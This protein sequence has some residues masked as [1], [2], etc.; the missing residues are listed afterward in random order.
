[1]NRKDP[2]QHRVFTGMRIAPDL[3]ERL[4]KFCEAHK[5]RPTRTLVM[6]TAIREFLD[7][8]HPVDTKT[9]PDATADT[10]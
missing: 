1:M 4:E 3:Y 7:R 9:Q 6:E 2:N 8:E 10:F 5:L